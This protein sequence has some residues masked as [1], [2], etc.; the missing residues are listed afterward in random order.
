MNLLRLEHFIDIHAVNSS[1]NKVTRILNKLRLS[2]NDTTSICCYMSIIKSHINFLKCWVKK[3]LKSK[4]RSIVLDR[5]ISFYLVLYYC[6][7]S[8]YFY[9]YFFLSTYGPN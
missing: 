5:H 4:A 6:Y 7:D 9:E 1:K 2:N 3:Y 8:F